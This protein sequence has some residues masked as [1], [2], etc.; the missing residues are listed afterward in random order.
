[1]NY[2]TKNNKLEIKHT[3]QKSSYYRSIYN[4]IIRQSPPGLIS[5]FEQYKFLHRPLNSRSSVSVYNAV[6]CLFCWWCNILEGLRERGPIYCLFS[7]YLLIN[8]QK[9]FI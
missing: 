9:T 6:L 3:F 2:K 1:M 5:Y 7:R 4:V 8:F